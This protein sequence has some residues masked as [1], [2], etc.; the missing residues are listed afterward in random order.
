MHLEK[1]NRGI[2]IELAQASAQGAAIKTKDAAAVFGHPF[3]LFNID[4]QS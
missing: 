4:G 1:M 3:K 2:D